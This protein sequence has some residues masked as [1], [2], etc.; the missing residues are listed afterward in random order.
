MGIDRLFENR[1]R[2]LIRLIKENIGRL[3]FAMLCSLMVAASTALSAFL[4]KNVID[5]IFIEKK[6]LMLKL[7]PLAIVVIYIVRCIGMYG[8][9]YMM[10]YVG[11][12]IIRRLRNMLYE[13]II[14]LPLAFFQEKKTGVLMSRITNDVTVIKGMVSTAVTGAFRDLFSIIGLTGVIFYRDWKMAL[15]AFVVFSGGPVSADISWQTGS[16][17][18]YRVPGGHGRVEYVSS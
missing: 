10:S 9:A 6:V 15:M 16:Q 14:D 17:G 5:D 11:E 2:H 8:Q 4:M 7:L 13:C 18:Q 12:S 3:V 1:H